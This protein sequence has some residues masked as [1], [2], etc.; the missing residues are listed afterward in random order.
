[1]ITFLIN[2][3]RRHWQVLSTVLFGVLISTAFLA[4]GPIIVNTV[5]D[6]ALP[7][8][9]RSSLVENGIIYLTTYNN[10]GEHEH[11]QINLDSTS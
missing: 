1:V 10:L 2:R 5:I 8:K 3:A 6:F 4:S 9:L 11:D 7:H